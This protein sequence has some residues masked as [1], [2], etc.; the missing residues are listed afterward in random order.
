MSDL[1]VKLYDLEDPFEL[2]KNMR[3]EGIVIR[4]AIGPEKYAI[5]SWVKEHFSEG[6]ASECDVSFSQCP[7]T[8]IIAVKDEKMVGF[9]CTDA[10]CRGFFGPTGVQ[11]DMRGQNIGK[12]LLLASLQD[13]KQRGYA[14][15]V[16]GSASSVSFYAKCCGA[17]VIEGSSP[18]IYKGMIG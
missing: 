8:C 18:G 11:E 5:L 14:Y 2:L 13:M 16:I 4:R 3:G 9:A 12:A 1:L 17:Q 15:A 6:W 10:T 7:P